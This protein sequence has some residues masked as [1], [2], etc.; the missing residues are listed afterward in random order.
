MDSQATCKSILHLKTRTKQ[1]SLAHLVPLHHV[2]EMIE[3]FDKITFH[4][5]PREENQMADALT[6]LVENDDPHLT[7]VKDYILSIPRLEQKEAD[8]KPWY[9]DIK[10]Y[11]K[12]GVYPKGI[13]ENDKRTLRKLAS[14]FFLSG[15]ILYKRSE[16]KEIMEEVHEGTFGTHANRHALA[17]KIL[18]VGYYWTGMESSCC[19]HVKRCIKC[20][21]YADN[22]HVAP[23]TLH[24]LTSPWPFSIWCLDMIGL[25]EPKASNRHKFFLVAIDYF[26][27][28]VEVA[29]YACV[30]KNVVVKFIKKGIICRYGGTNLN[31]KMM[32]KLCEQFKI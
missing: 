26:T 30:M 12:K 2:K 6:T 10:K 17:Q 25:I 9:H 1:P 24:N 20:Q 11:L 23:S 29:S 14:G 15:T 3:L 8:V 4:H 13:S 31:N 22:I 27:K 18:R 32:T 7:S 21:I 5:I 19:Q 16:A 28:W